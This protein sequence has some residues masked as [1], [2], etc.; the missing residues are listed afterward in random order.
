MLNKTPYFTGLAIIAVAS[1]APASSL[2]NAPT[3]YV[4]PTE[5]V[6][7]A[8]NQQEEAGGRIKSGPGIRNPTIPNGIAQASGATLYDDPCQEI[9]DKKRTSWCKIK[10]DQDE[11]LFFT[12]VSGLPGLADGAP[13]KLGV[14]RYQIE[15][16]EDFYIPFSLLAS[17]VT[18]DS[19]GDEA[20]TLKLLDPEQG[21]NFGFEQAWRYKMG[22][23]CAGITDARCGLMVRG[24]L[25]YLRLEE[26]DTGTKESLYG[27]FVDIKNQWSFKISDLSGDEAGWLRLGFGASYFSHGGDKSETFFAGIVDGDGNAV[28]FDGDYFST[29]ASAEFTITN[30]VSIK[31]E[32]YEPHG[33]DGLH[34]RDAVTIHY[35]FLGRE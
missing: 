15:L 27:G 26:A 11:A 23:V 31:Y 25:R 32:H 35:N 33:A 22:R 24:G 5:S 14:A 29:F 18:G 19:E 4:A 28:E 10:W 34:S 2:L 17:D 13:I 1:Q 20:N 7:P 3:K 30:S 8:S 12:D 16:G 9:W 6:A 21:I